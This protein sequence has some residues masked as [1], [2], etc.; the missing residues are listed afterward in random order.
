MGPRAG[1]TSSLGE[2][3]PDRGAQLVVP[4]TE[5]LRSLIAAAQGSA[6]EVP[7]L[8]AATTGMRRSEVLAVRWADVDLAA[9]RVRVTRSLQRLADGP[10]RIFDPKT[11]RSRRELALAAFVLP[12]L[13]AHR[14]AQRLRF[15]QLGRQHTDAELICDRGDGQPIDPSTFSHAFK[16][17][18]KQAGIP[19]GARLHDARHAVATALL[20]RQVHPAI[21]SAMLGHASE[22][23]TMATYQHVTPRMTEAAAAVLDGALGPSVPGAE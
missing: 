8:F 17:L 23:F 20:E 16:R 12:L 2:A 13:R 22:S 14:D 21:A 5:Q 10:I 7:I 4:T 11:S 18:A 6:W 15:E 9:G 3:A 19:V 1:E